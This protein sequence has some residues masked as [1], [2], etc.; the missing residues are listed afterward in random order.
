MIEHIV[1]RVRKPREIFRRRPLIVD[2]R[3]VLDPVFLLET[4]L[5]KIL[6]D[7]IFCRNTVVLNEKRF[8]VSISALRKRES[9]HREPLVDVE[10]GN[11]ESVSEQGANQ[12][13]QE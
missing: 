5:G 13:E 8:N 7:E 1:D 12:D 6:S 11:D 3:V 10:S 2:A 9:A 4:L